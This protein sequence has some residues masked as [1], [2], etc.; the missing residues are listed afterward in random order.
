MA[1]GYFTSFIGK[2]HTQDIFNADEKAIFLMPD[3]TL[4]S[5]N[6]RVTQRV[7][8]MFADNM[9]GSEDFR[10]LLIGKRN[11]PRCFIDCLKYIEHIKVRG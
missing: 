9:N 2:Q 5:T 1:R 11:A 3:N 6:Y 7:T 10:L 8:L 4:T